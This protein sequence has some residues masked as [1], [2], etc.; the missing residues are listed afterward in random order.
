MWLIGARNDPRHCATSEPKGVCEANDVG[1][2]PSA[3]AALLDEKRNHVDHDKGRSASVDRLVCMPSS[4]SL[5]LSVILTLLN[6]PIVELWAW[7]GNIRCNCASLIRNHLGE[8][9]CDATMISGRHIGVNDL[10]LRCL[11]AQQTALPP[12]H[13]VFPSLS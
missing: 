8:S 12:S 3:V 13:G 5:L 10:N 7:V 2:Y 4:T 9:L 1:K 11:G 6:Q